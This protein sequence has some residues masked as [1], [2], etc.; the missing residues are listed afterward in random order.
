MQIFHGNNFL[1]LITTTSWTVSLPSSTYTYFWRVVAVNLAGETS[2]L[3][4][5]SFTSVFSLL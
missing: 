5:R 1:A 2:S 3:E 4:A